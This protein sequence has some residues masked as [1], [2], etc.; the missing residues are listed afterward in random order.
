MEKAPKDLLNE[1]LSLSNANLKLAEENLRLKLRFKNDIEELMQKA[2]QYAIFC[3]RCAMNQTPL[4]SF[5]DWIKL[6]GGNK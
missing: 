4:I 2:Q 3:A 1:L 6:E 5:K